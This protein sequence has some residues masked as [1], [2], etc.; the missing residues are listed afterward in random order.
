MGMKA[1]WHKDD[2]IREVVVTLVT[3]I[4]RQP[5]EASVR[6]PLLASIALQKP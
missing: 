5:A 3:Q 1:N 6:M 2:G 4:S